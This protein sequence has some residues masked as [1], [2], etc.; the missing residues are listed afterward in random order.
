MAML[1]AMRCLLDSGGEERYGMR[2]PA[3]RRKIRHWER[4]FVLKT[5]RRLFWALLVLAFMC[6]LA[7]FM[8]LMHFEL[9]LNPLI[10]SNVVQ[11]LP[12]TREFPVR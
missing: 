11:D 6:V 10:H 9:R 2:N 5:G 4:L 3:V 7:K 12:S 8:L 1:F